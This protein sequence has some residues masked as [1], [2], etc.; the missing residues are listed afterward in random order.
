MDHEALG[1]AVAKRVDLGMPAFAAGERIVV[2]RAAVVVE[3]QDLA[4]IVHRI[5]SGLTR[6]AEGAHIEFAV[7]PEEQPRDTARALGDEDVLDVGQPAAVENPAGERRHGA[8]TVAALVVGHVDQA[9]TLEVRM[10]LDVEQAA[11][12]IGRDV[13]GQPGDRIRQL[14]GAEQAQAPGAL[15]DEDRAVGQEGEAPGIL[16]V[17]A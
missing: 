2:G 12:E 14:A 16:R 7:R 11:D 5:L 13:I 15:G 3:S 6:L 8:L 4:G 10:Q 1:R 9:V 17:R